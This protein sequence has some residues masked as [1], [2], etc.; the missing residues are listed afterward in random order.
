MSTQ[1]KEKEIRRFCD[2]VYNDSLAKFDAKEKKSL[3]IFQDVFHDAEL[4]MYN[5]LDVK[6]Y[7]GWENNFDRHDEQ[8]GILHD[9]FIKWWDSYKGNYRSRYNFA[10][11]IWG[12]LHAMFYEIGYNINSIKIDDNNEEK[13]EKEEKEKAHIDY[14]LFKD[15]IDAMVNDIEYIITDNYYDGN[16]YPV[17]KTEISFKNGYKIY[18]LHDTPVDWENKSYIWHDDYKNMISKNIEES[19]NDICTAKFDTYK[20]YN[21]TI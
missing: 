8:G 15:E 20:N 13:E 19:I 4:F 16:L 3:E 12:F 17:L 18:C 21:N 9:K 11:G 14:D 7:C 2:Q 6:A 5:E 1:K 10:E